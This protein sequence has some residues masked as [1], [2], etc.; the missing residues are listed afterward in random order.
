MCHTGIISVRENAIF[1]H[2]NFDRTKMSHLLQTLFKC[3]FTTRCIRQYT[4]S[5]SFYERLYYILYYSDIKT[6][7][8]TYETLKIW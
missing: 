1:L 4:P 7:F 3:G 6:C 5:F 2:Q 8:K